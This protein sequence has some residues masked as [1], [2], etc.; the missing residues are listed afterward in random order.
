MSGLYLA[1]L[2]AV[3]FGLVLCISVLWI[4]FSWTGFLLPIGSLDLD[5]DFVQ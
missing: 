4:G 5:L 3:F 2:D 1:F